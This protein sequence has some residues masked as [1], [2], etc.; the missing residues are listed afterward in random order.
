MNLNIFALIQV[1]KIFGK[2]LFISNVKFTMNDCQDKI[3]VL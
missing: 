2:Y 1:M 3:V